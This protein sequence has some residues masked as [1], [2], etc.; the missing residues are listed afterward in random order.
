MCITYSIEFKKYDL[1]KKLAT[2]IVVLRAGRLQHLF[3]PRGKT[4]TAKTRVTGHMGKDNSF[5]LLVYES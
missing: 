3:F 2:D 1:R 5:Y 4:K